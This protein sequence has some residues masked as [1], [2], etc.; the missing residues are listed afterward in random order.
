MRTRVLASLALLVSTGG[1]S[2]VPVSP[3]ASDSTPIV[4]QGDRDREQKI[5]HFIKVLTPAPIR[6]Q[7]SRFESAVCPTVRGIADQQARQV[8]DRIRQVAK[9]VGVQAAKPGCIT[10]LAVFVTDDKPGTL[11]QLGRH[12]G[13]FP[14]DWDAGQIRNFER[15]TSQI[16]RAHV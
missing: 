6:G 14:Q 15:D 5:E 3:P 8:E 1:Q 7:L 12:P 10:N 16:G 4:V 11:H 2:Q 13:M 9:A